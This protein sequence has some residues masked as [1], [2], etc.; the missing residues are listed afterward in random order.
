MKVGSGALAPAAPYDFAATI[1]FIECFA[2]GAGE[3]R[4]DDSHI[5]R[6]VTVDGHAIGFSV[7]S[8]GTLEAPLLAYELFAS[9]PVSQHTL[10][11]A[12]ERIAFYLSIDDRLHPFYERAAVDPSMARLTQA[13]YGFH[14]VKF[15]TPF[16]NACHGILSQRTPIAL[17][18]RRKDAL[19][20]RFGGGVTIEG[21][22]HRAFPNAAQLA[23]CP[24]EKLAEAIAHP[25]SARRLLGCAHAFA[26]VDEEWLRS[27]PVDEVEQ[28]LLD[29]EGVG[30][31]TAGFVLIR[32]L[33]RLEYRVTPDE[34]LIE[35]YREIY[36]EPQATAAEVRRVADGYA[37]LSGLW[38][39]YLRAAPR[40]LA[41]A[42]SV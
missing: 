20:A 29:I 7:T 39:V 41:L 6:A 9:H 22:L 15:M 26:A 35:A 42:S 1:R 30:P 25:L 17:M 28:W 36:A 33:G 24:I 4:V 40:A 12:R 38:A 21:V 37:P 3:Q 14:Q 23:Q 19:V 8:E 13:A 16:E 10:Q 5:T 34:P 18:K 11:A 27:A 2:P 31:W 32:G